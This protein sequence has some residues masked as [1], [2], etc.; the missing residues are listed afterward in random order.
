MNR[1]AYTLLA[2]LLVAGCGGP[3]PP[4]EPIDLLYRSLAERKEPHDFSFLAGRTIL[5][6]P[7]HGGSM[8]GTTGREGLAEKDVNLGVAL[9]LWGLLVDAGADARLTRTADSD[10]LP[11]GS[12][13]LADDLAA[14]VALADSIEPDLFLSIHHNAAADT[15]RSRNLVETYYREGD[16][17]PSLDAA[18][19]IHDHLMRN[20]GIGEGE[21]RPGNYY[22][23]RKNR[24]PAVLGE[25]SYLSHPPVEKKLLLAEKRRLEAEAYFLGIADYFRRCVPTAVIDEPSGTIDR[26]D[27]LRLSGSLA[28]EAGGAGIDPGTVSVTLD[29]RPLPVR[30]HPGSG[31]ATAVLPPDIAPGEHRA[32]LGGRN[33]GGN[34]AIEAEEIF[35][36][37]LPPV[38][39]DVQGTVLPGGGGIELELALLDERGLPVADGTMVAVEGAGESG[40]A[41]TAEVRS[42]RAL[43][44]LPGEEPPRSIRLGVDGRSLTALVPSEQVK[45]P[46]AAILVLGGSNGERPLA[47]AAVT[48][49]DGRTAHAG[50][51]GH[52]LLGRAIESSDRFIFE[53]AG[54]RACI[55]RG[56]DFPSPAGGPFRL[57]PLTES[58]LAGNRIVVDPDGG[59]GGDDGGFPPSARSLRLALYLVEM[60]RWAGADAALTRTGE[61]VP[62]V[63]RRIAVANRTGADYW[64]T[65]RYGGTPVVR[66]FPGSREGTPLAETTAGYLKSYLYEP[67]TTRDGNEPVLGRTPCPAMV[68]RLPI[69]EERGRLSRARMRAAAQSILDALADRLDEDPAAR[70]VLQIERRFPGSLVRIDGAVTFQDREAAVFRIHQVPPGLHRLEIET[71]NGWVDTLVTLEPARTT[72]IR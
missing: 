37:R 31:R 34:A 69:E 10:L 65:L 61:T 46:A 64:I 35:Q 62:S 20:L 71:A 4:E 7:G 12:T 70:A 60:L 9:Y 56:D 33:L 22:V 45:R 32:A 55:G 40:V 39:V 66:H 68:I 19:A 63:D 2:L 43:L 1:F 48:G 15:N 58:P 50:A 54:H 59:D 57:I 49:P 13:D 36:V 23:L 51:G 14:R 38:R 6:D 3:P 53:A 25:P 16:G 21:V 30:F 29:G 11:D 72:V 41:H 28:D 17:G 52:A 18:R 24:F 42:G 8:T 27:G 47:G 44:R 26:P 67:F 5:I